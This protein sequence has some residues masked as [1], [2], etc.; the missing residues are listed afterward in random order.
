MPRSAL[1]LA[2]GSPS[3]ATSPRVGLRKPATALSSVDFPQ[4]FGRVVAQAEIRDRDFA[5]LDRC[6]GCR[7][8][9]LAHGMTT[10]P[11]PRISA[12]DP[13]PSTPMQ[14]MPSAMSAYCTSE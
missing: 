12:L 2:T 14:I 7:G 10:R 9:V 4:P 13:R 6:S 8:H 11:T 5:L 1:G 3:T